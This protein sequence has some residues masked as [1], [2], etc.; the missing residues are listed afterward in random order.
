MLT[1]N[2]KAYSRKAFQL[3]DIRRLIF[4]LSFVFLSPLPV[5][6][7]TIIMFGLDETGSYNLRAKGV[8]LACMVIDG[9][10]GGDVF[11][12]RRITDRSFHDS[13]SVFRLE[14]PAVGKAPQNRFDR[15]TRA[16]WER[17]VQAVNGAKAKAKDMLSRLS[18]VKAPRT[19]IRGFLAAC[20]ARF[21][22][23]EESNGITR[24]IIIA[25]DM[26]E[27]VKR[28]VSLDLQGA[29]VM[30]VG[31]EAGEDPEASRKLQEG[32]SDHLARCKAGKVRF[33]PADSLFVVNP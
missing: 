6:A 28:S 21:Q 29:E 2:R 22:A 19:D 3:L 31:F 18:P 4:V 23:E 30:I 33:L 24:K 25:S 1:S 26:K 9:L 12:V 10:H 13:A 16:T 7:R 20:T 32:W 14:I 17:Q 15:T 5:N 27:N 8:A 11:Y